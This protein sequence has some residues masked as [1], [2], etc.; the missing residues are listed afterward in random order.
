MC[1]LQV[2]MESVM[3]RRDN[4]ISKRMSSLQRKDDEFF[5][6][7]AT[8]ISIIQREFNTTSN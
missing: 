4:E 5:N 8:A 1:D 6:K 2:E 7:I 3:K